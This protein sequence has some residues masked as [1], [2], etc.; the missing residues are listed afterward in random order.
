MVIKGLSKERIQRLTRFIELLNARLV[1]MSEEPL[2]LLEAHK[3][4]QP[5]NGS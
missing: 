5:R 4:Y 2:D 1:G 3:N